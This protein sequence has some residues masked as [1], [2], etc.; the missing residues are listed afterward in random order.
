[1]NIEHEI[2]LCQNIFTLVLDTMEEELKK[3][4][5]PDLQKDLIRYCT[6]YGL[7]GGLQ[8]YVRKLNKNQIEE[9][10]RRKCGCGDMTRNI[11]D[12]KK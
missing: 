6:I 9:L 5:L 2:K 4:N 11:K 3:T 12:F 1:M 8:I 7:I 10:N